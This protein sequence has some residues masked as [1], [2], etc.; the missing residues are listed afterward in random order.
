MI[1]I[2]AHILPD[3]DDGPIDLEESLEMARAG[4]SEGIRTIIATP[5]LMT[6][7]SQELVDRFA[8]VF[9]SLQER[10]SADG[11][12]V[13]LLLGSE[14]YFQPEMDKVK[15][16]PGLTLN[17]TGKHLLMEFPMQGIPEGAEQVLTN[18]IM[19]GLI[20][21]VAHPERNLSVLR[22]ESILE[23]I[24]RGGALIQV[25]AGSIEGEFGK[26][27]KKTALSL[28]KREMVHFIGSDAH[29]A[30]NRPVSLRKAVESAAEVIGR[31]KALDLVT[32]NPAKI[33]MGYPLPTRGLLPTQS[34]ESGLLRK[35]WRGVTGK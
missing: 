28:L 24:V 26:Q 30:A 23:S 11:P 32:R 29:D 15:D 21:I 34:Q 9:G 6:M 19:G 33:L 31:E 22:D 5:H 27:V 20:P 14:I 12:P 7:P 16:F 2:H 8:E 4:W 13:H 35:V 25:N 17:G 10:I 3:V 1:D 18:L